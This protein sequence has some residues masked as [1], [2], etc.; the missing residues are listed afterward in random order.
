VFLTLPN[1]GP[2][3]SGPWNDVRHL[4]EDRNEI[5]VDAYVAIANVLLGDIALTVTRTRDWAAS[6]IPRA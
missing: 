6:L 1:G 3:L 2:T 4:T 5:G